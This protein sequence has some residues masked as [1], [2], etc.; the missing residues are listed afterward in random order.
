[1]GN[2]CSKDLAKEGGNYYANIHVPKPNP[3]NLNPVKRS[4]FSD[5][6]IPLFAPAADVD[7]DDIVSDPETLTD[8]ELNIY[9][10]KLEK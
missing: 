2:C 9:A 8:D 3:I 5:D 6:V 1:M 10:S 7:S 4:D